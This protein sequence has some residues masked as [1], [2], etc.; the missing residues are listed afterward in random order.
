MPHFDL[1]SPGYLPMVVVVVV[2]VMIKKLADFSA[3][4]FA[5]SESDPS[6][7][8]SKFQLWD[9]IN[10]LGQI[11]LHGTEYCLDAGS[12]PSNAGPA[13]I[14]SCGDYPQQKWQKSGNMLQTTNSE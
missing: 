11:K 3:N 7:G 5:Q 4:C 8:N 12:N 2:V 6:L 1:D 10:S 9:E 14:W 13:K